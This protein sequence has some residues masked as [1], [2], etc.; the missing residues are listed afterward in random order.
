MATPQSWTFVAGLAVGGLLFVG[1]Y[2]TGRSSSPAPPAP[3][4]A[5][6]PSS[7]DDDDT[8]P[9]PI[10]PRP[11]S[12]RSSK[13]IARVPSTTASEPAPD[14]LLQVDEDLPVHA[15]ADD[16]SPVIGTAPR[17][18][19]V[20]VLEVR[21]GYWRIALPGDGAV[22]GWILRLP[23]R[24]AGRRPAGPSVPGRF[25]T[26][27][28]RG[29]VRLTGTPPVMRVPKKRRDA[30]LCKTKD[31]PADAVVAQQ[32]K[33]AGVFVGL[34]G[35]PGAYAPPAAP[36][37]V[38]QE[39]CAYRPRIQGALVGQ[40]LEVRNQDGTLHSVHTYRGVEAW[41]DKPQIRGA[42][43]IHAELP[44][45]PDVVKLTCD[46][47]PWMRAFVVVADSPFFAVS[48]ADGS[49][50][51]ERV[52]SGRHT[53]RAWHPHYGEKTITVDVS[54]GAASSTSLTYDGTE[55]EPPENVN[56]L[57]DLF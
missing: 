38:E 5:P 39:D 52:P 53:L 8:A 43:P 2:W 55:P 6:P 37:I 19:E 57:K 45:A 1:G 40:Q 24:D 22:I 13:E 51:L 7:L 32:G 35:I 48:G 11:R 29:I 33:L 16:G 20:R 26:A 34:T 30:E 50:L 15:S 28:I 41:F 31:V 56:E 17:G 14:T 3:P 23:P 36:V 4:E 47:H 18:A 27:T 54:D 10:T 12:R 21:G 9:A 44:E 25:G 49:F 42:D 46:V